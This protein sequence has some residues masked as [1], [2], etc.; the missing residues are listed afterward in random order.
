MMVTLFDVSI[1]TVSEHLTNIYSSGELDR[2][3]TVRKFRIVQTED[4]RQ[5]SRDIEYSG[6]EQNPYHCIFIEKNGNAC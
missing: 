1:K 4:T 5:V 2:E 6:K 3:S